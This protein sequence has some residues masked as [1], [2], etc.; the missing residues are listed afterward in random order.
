M[1]VVLKMNILRY[2][3]LSSLL[4]DFFKYIAQI[5]FSYTAAY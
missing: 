3:L 2:Y 1:Y 4:S 5:S